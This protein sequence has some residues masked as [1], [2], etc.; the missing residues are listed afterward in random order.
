MHP[1][2]YSTRLR[3]Y[4]FSA[5]FFIASIWLFTKLFDAFSAQSLSG[6][7]AALRASPWGLSALA[8]YIV[9][10]VFAA[11]FIWLRE[12]PPLLYVHHKIVA[13]A[14]P[15]LGNPV[16]LL[17]ISYVIYTY[18]SVELTFVPRS[19]SPDG[20]LVF[21]P[22]ANRRQ[23]KL[24]G[25]IFAVLL[26]L[27]LGV[28]IWAFKVQP[29]SDGVKDFSNKWVA[30]TFQDN[31]GG[32]LFTFVYV[33]IREDGV[34]SVVIPWFLGLALLG[35]AA[36]CFYVIKLAHESIRRDSSFTFLLLSKS[37]IQ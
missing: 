19:V 5:I 37:K 3:A 8:D 31:L 13:I 29:L 23:T 11:M 26:V 34:P 33:L 35:N 7:G 30:F 27:F 10:A 4:F 12:T 22:P 14:F 24:V 20:E 6:G 36:T 17:Y 15:F 16:L 25:F 18:K 32:L 9:G 28:C 1:P 2:S 21:H